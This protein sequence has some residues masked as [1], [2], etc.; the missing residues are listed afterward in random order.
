MNM[1]S[2]ISSGK[3]AFQLARPLKLVEVKHMQ[4]H[5]WGYMVCN[6]LIA[7]LLTALFGISLKGFAGLLAIEAAVQML[8]MAGTGWVLLIFFAFLRL[9]FP[10]ALAYTNLLGKLMVVGLLVLVP[11]MLL[12]FVFN[13]QYISIPVL[14][15]FGSSSLMLYLHYTICKYLQLPHYWTM[16]WFVLL[17]GGAVTWTL[18]FYF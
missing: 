18:Y 17:Q 8:L 16:Y 6:V 2:K 4:L 14:S 9:S 1:S 10:M 15:V 13:L 7:L 5:S 11:S 3:D 12:H